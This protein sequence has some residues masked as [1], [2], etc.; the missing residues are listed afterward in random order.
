MQ[1]FFGLLRAAVSIYMI[2]ITVRIILTWFRGSIRI[3]DA[4]AAATDPYLKWFQRFTFLRIGNLDLS[5]IAALGVL[6]VLNQVLGRLQHSG[7]IKLGVLLAL[8]VQVVWSAVSF[9]MVFLIIVL[10]LRLIG[11]MASQ[12]AYGGF[13]SIIDTITRPVLYRLN[14]IFFKG[15]I[16]N[17]RTQIIVSTAAMILIYFIL[18]IGINIIINILVKFPI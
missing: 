9:F 18:L 5:P 7:S 15:R 11:L 3:P 1:L 10:V 2:V 13:W 6:S 14:Q 8:I 16:T 17:F 12:N 4:L